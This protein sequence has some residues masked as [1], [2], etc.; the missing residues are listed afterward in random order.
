VFF[1]AA[2]SAVSI[3]R[4]ASTCRDADRPAEQSAGDGA[5]ALEAVIG[6]DLFDG[7]CRRIETDDQA[8][9][10]RSDHQDGENEE[11]KT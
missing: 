6:Y 1:A 9:D 7:V 5:S 11:A 2:R 3:S 8:D 10:H 4:N